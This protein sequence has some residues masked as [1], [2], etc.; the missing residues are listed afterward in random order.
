VPQL[1]GLLEVFFVESPAHIRHVFGRV[2]IQMNLAAPNRLHGWIVS[3]SEKYGSSGN[4]ARHNV[5]VPDCR[6][7]VIVTTG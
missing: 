6:G 5:D 3:Y 7:P 2:E 4:N 1:Q